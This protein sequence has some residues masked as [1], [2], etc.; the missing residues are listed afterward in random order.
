MD[1]LPTRADWI[2]GVAL[3]LAGAALGFLIGGAA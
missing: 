2:L 1:Q 3:L